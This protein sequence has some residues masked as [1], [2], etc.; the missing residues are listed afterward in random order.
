MF[1]FIS[2]NWRG[3]P[4]VSYRTIVELISNTTTTKG[5]KIRAQ[6]DLNYY[7]T[8]TKISAAKMATVPLTPHEFHGTGT[9]RL[10]NQSIG[11]SFLTIASN[12]SQT[13][14]E[15]ESTLESGQ[16][17]VTT[18][19]SSTSESRAIP[20]LFSQ[21]EDD[22]GTSRPASADREGTE[23]CLPADHLVGQLQCDPGAR[24]PKRVSNRHRPASY[25]ENLPI[26][27]PNGPLASQD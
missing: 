1:S 3:R 19:T 23:L 18:P 7:E 12:S 26:Y 25:V 16:S 6:E 2:M 5:L 10:R 8:G 20:A 4:L 14:G 11:E 27:V 21:F 22:G 9:T 15:I 13:A 24:C 17:S